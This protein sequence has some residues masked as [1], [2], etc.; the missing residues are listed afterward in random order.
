M[1]DAPVAAE[2]VEYGRWWVHGSLGD[3][4]TRRTGRNG[5]TAATVAKA[6]NKQEVRSC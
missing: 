6:D 3:S 2:G 5:K 1:D 4:W